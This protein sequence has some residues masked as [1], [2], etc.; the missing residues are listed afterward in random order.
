MLQ[1][2]RRV[3]REGERGGRKGQAC[4]TWRCREDFL[5]PGALSVSVVYTATPSCICT[6]R[7]PTVR[8]L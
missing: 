7:V 1:S 3:I 6:H 2:G 8:S 4:T 5:A